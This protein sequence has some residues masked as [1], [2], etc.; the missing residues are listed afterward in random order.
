MAEPVTGLRDATRLLAASGVRIATLETSAGGRIAAALTALP[1]SSAWFDCGEVAYSYPARLRLPGMVESDLQREGAVSA[2]AV[3]KLCLAMLER[4]DAGLVLAES[5]V[6]GPDGG[7]PEKPV[8][9][10][11]LCWQMRDHAPWVKACR[12]S[13]DREAVFGQIVEAALQG[14]V[15]LLTGLHQSMPCSRSDRHS[16]K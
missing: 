14:I 9:S 1:G 2:W 11:F 8:G 13:G 15:D 4:S 12:F 3:E 5:F 7:L 10:G 6:V 16:P